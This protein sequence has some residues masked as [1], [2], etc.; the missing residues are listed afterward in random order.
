MPKLRPQRVISQIMQSMYG[1][2]KLLPAVMLCLGTADHIRFP[3]K[4][5]SV[6]RLLNPIKSA[7]VRLVMEFDL[8][9]LE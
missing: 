9:I 6:V 2:A 8:R 3:N 1:D 5:Y 4:A 7:E